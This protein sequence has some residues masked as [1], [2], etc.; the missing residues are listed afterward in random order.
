M[1]AE[2]RPFAAR[3]QAGLDVRVE[4]DQADR[5]LLTDHQVA[6]RRGEADGV[7]ELG[8]LLAIGVGHRGAEVHHQIAGDVRL[9]LELFEVVFVGL[10]VDVPVEVFEV[11]AGDV[12]AVF[13]ELDAEA[14]KRAG[15]QAGQKA[16]DD[17]AGAQVEPRHLA[18]DV[19]SQILLGSGHAFIIT[20][21]GEKA[22]VCPR[23]S[24]DL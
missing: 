7:I 20:N 21:C 10:G 15:V 8:Q 23:R 2:V 5:V 3:R 16:F 18:D 14:L 19:G 9:G 11:V 12:L 4:G 6:E 13:G 22:F 24:K 17:E 1:A